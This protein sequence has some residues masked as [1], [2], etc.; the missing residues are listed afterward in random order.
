VEAPRFIEDQRDVTLRKG[1]SWLPMHG[2]LRKGITSLM[3]KPVVNIVRLASR[4]M[5]FKDR[6][7][8]PKLI[9]T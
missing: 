9:T 7:N 6:L 3:P 8:D 1:F 5:P 4:E 2:V